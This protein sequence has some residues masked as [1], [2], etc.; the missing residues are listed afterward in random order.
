MNPDQLKTKI[1]TSNTFSDE[2]RKTIAAIFWQGFGAKMGRFFGSESQAIGF[3]TESLGQELLHI[4]RDEDGEI[5]GMAGCRTTGNSFLTNSPEMLRKHYGL[6][7]GFWRSAA[8]SL[9][10]PK[11]PEEV[12]LIDAVSVAKASRGKGAGK[13]LVEACLEDAKKR[14]LPTA[15]LEVLEENE[16]VIRLY[17]RLGFKT[18]GKRPMGVIVRFM[19]IREVVQMRSD[20]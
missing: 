16:V 19:G 2:E 5:L 3:L 10:E 1:T 8:L 15:T 12:Y 20:L 13:V 7:G 14:G 18:V 6:F 17:K 4:A 9:G 11:V